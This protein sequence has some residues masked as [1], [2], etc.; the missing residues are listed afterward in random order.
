MS[1]T[2]GSVP[3]CCAAQDL[4][5]PTNPPTQEE[6]LLAV[7]QMK[8][9]KAAGLHSIIIAEAL[10]NGGDAMVDIVHGFC[11]EVLYP[12]HATQPVDHQ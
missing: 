3:S 4:P 12:S 5:I 9:N 11:A 8:T 2:I 10:Q 1:I 7:L 6:T